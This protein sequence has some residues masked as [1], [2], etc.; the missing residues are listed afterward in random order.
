MVRETGRILK[1]FG[2]PVVCTDSWPVESLIGIMKRDKKKLNKDNMCL[3][4]RD[5]GKVEIVRDVP[6][7][8]IK[9][10]LHQLLPD[11]K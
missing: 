7:E 1:S 8:E 3:Y 10:V 2:L 4:S 6:E 9:R 5:I 11:R